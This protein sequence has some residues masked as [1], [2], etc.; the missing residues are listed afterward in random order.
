MANGGQQRSRNLNVT[1]ATDERIALLDHDDLWDPQ[2]LAETRTLMDRAVVDLI[3][4]NSRTVHEHDGHTEVRV[5]NRFRG[6]AP[7]GY[8]AAMGAAMGA[9][10]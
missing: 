2:Y 4:C 5:A 1:E 6:G 7:A 8:W 9:A 3:F 10:R